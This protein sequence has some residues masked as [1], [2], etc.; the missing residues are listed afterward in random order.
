MI[1]IGGSNPAF[2]LLPTRVWNLGFGVL[3][4]LIFVNKK[5]THSN[6][7]AL[8]LILLIFIGVSYEIP[9][10]PTNF[11]IVFA[12]FMFLRKKL[13]KKFIFKKVI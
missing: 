8:A 10:L 9:Y 2:F 1:N 12:C 11:L 3:A 5:K 6:F 13:P 7:E 4:M